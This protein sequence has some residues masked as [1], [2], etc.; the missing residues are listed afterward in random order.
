MD[1]GL[2]RSRAVLFRSDDF[3]DEAEEVL[4]DQG[5]GL[6]YSRAFTDLS[7][8]GGHESGR[9]GRHGRVGS[10]DD[11]RQLVGCG[12]QCRKLHKHYFDCWLKR[13]AY[14]WLDDAG[15]PKSDQL[16]KSAKLDYQDFLQKHRWRVKIP[17]VQQIRRAA[18]TNDVALN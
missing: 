4:R 2:Q 1:E 12:T 18:Q 16:K 9:F 15:R 8:G 5:A 7:V 3:A 6:P 13:N 17:H 10:Q 11:A 14:E